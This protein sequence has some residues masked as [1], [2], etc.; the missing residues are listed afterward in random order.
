M[1]KKFALSFLG[2][3]VLASA[4]AT[5]HAAELLI[6]GSF[7]TPVQTNGDHVGTGPG[8]PWVIAGGSPNLVRGPVTTGTVKPGSGATSNLPVDPNDKF[9]GGSQQLLDINATGTASQTFVA[10]FNAPATIKFDIGGRD[11]VEGDN[12]TAPTGS[13]WSLFNNSTNVLVANSITLNPVINQWLTNTSTTAASLT[14]GVTYRFVINLDNPDQVDGL[15]ITQVPEPTT[16]T[17][18]GVGLGLLGWLGYQRRRR[19]S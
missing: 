15:S 18:A 10:Q 9:A 2:A 6:N 8:T 17:A 7:E 13:T 5:G 4:P 1:N 19:Q 11:N 12:T 3:A 16:A 14:A